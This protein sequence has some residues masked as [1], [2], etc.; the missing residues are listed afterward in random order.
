MEAQFWKPLLE[1]PWPRL[2]EGL[3]LAKA[4][5]ANSM[6]DYKD[7]NA[8]RKDFQRGSECPSSSGMRLRPLRG[9]PGVILW[10]TAEDRAFWLAH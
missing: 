6:V 3:T 9:A 10:G 8:H 2:G 4:L 1:Y 5:S 7:C